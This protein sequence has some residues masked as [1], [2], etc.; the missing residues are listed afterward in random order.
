MSEWLEG[1]DF[2]SELLSCDDG[3]RALRLTVYTDMSDD[4]SDPASLSRTWSQKAAG[5][6]QLAQAD[7]TACERK[8]IETARHHIG[9][10]QIRFFN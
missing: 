5:P 9:V 1:L 6:Y 10:V 7:H 3:R 4:S 2:P 8:W